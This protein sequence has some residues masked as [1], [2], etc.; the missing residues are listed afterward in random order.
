MTQERSETMPIKVRV[1]DHLIAKFGDESNW[2]TRK[3]MA[4]AIGVQSSTV[5]DWVKNRIDR[6]TLD[7][8]DKWCAYLDVEPG[9]ILVREVDDDA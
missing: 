1:R 5:A 7:A 3:E 6:L 4:D 9:D 8:L 2:P